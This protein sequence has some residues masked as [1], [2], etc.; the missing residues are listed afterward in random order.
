M[1]RDSSV[2]RDAASVVDIVTAARKAVEFVGLMDRDE[3]DADEKTQSGVLHQL[4]LIG[5]ATKRL[6][7]D[8]KHANTGVHWKQMAGMRDYLIHEYDQVDVDEVWST[9]SEDLP[10]LIEQIEPLVQRRES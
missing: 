5:E 2:S 1:P 10:A 4:M 6:S 3:F 9:V 7:S 8:F